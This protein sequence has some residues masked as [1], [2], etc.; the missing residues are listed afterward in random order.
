MG[1]DGRDDVEEAA[2]DDELGAVVGGGD[3]YGGGAE[4]EDA[5]EDVENAVA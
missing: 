4:I 3:L 2:Y 1:I 5:G